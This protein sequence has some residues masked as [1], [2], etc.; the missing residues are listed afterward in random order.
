[1]EETGERQIVIPYSLDR[2][3]FMA[4]CNQLSCLLCILYL[5]HLKVF[6]KIY[7]IKKMIY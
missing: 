2:A 5:K 1:M 3:P 4:A 6:I 7:C